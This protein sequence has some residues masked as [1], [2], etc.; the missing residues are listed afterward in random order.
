MS[1]I[2]HE[3]IAQASDDADDG[4]DDDRDRDGP[5]HPT[6]WRCPTDDCDGHLSASYS[7]GGVNRRE[8]VAVCPRCHIGAVAK[9][10]LQGGD[11]RSKTETRLRRSRS[12]IGDG[13][14]NMYPS[15]DSVSSVAAVL[16]DDFR[17]GDYEVRRVAGDTVEVDLPPQVTP[18]AVGD[19]VTAWYGDNGDQS[20]VLEVVDV[21]TWYPA[22]EARSWGY[23][24]T[25]RT[26][27]A[28][29]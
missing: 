21:Q 3:L 6:G 28:A 19:F 16:T 15:P 8:R 1:K 22:D 11:L 29:P 18:A 2:Q 7:H 23:T 24:V 5:R 13:S 20:D 27:P 17:P 26:G 9:V 12:K 4:T 25:I 14:G 10:E